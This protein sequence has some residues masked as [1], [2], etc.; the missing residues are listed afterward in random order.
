MISMRDVVGIDDEK[1]IV[2]TL[3]WAADGLLRT[4]LHDAEGSS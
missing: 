3:Q 4:A 2:A 1:E